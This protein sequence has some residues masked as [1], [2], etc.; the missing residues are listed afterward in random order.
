MP[1]VKRRR[2]FEALG[3]LSVLLLV[4][5]ACGDDPEA[6]GTTGAGGGGTAGTE[7]GGTATGGAAGEG[8]KS[9]GGGGSSGS[10]GSGEGGDGGDTG[11]AGSSAGHGAGNGGTTGQGGSAG[12]GGTSGGAGSGGEGGEPP[13]GPVRD[14]RCDDASTSALQGSGTSGDPYLVCLPEQLALLGTGPH[15]LDLHYELGDELDLAELSIPVATFTTAFTGTLDGRLHSITNLTGALFTVVGP[16]GAIIDLAVSGDVDAS[17][18]S[19][20]WGLLTRN[21]AGTLRRVR[22]SGTLNVGDHVGILLGTNE[23]LVEDCSSSGAITSGGAHVGGL[24]GVNLGTVRRSWSTAAVN[25]G[26]R[27]GGLVGRQTQP[28]VIE[29]SYARGAV[30][31]VQSPG[32]LLGTMFGGAIVDSY[33]RSSGVT[34]PEGGGLVG[35]FSGASGGAAISVTRSYSTSTLSGAGSEGLVGNV[36]G[37]PDYVVTS[38]YFLDVAPGTVGTARTSAEMQAQ[39]S[40]T[41]WAFGSTWKMDAALSAYPS[42]GFETR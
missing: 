42:L 18:Q 7:S 14:P 32:G 24:V 19:T 26:R 11:A 2:G 38:S 4:P 41:G 13:D 39:N 10:S 40:Y 37:T 22:A 15:T 25:G 16:G 30:T 3:L 20:S 27:V 17:S 6:N 21:N 33:A 8:G 34:G 31:A 9:T 1:R 28:G 36:E 12:N 29:Q 5:Q 23:G 35:D